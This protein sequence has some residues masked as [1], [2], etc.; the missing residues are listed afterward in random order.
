MSDVSQST[1]GTVFVKIIMAH[2]FGI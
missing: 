1:L 2:Y